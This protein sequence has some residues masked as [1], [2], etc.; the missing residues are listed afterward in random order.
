[1]NENSCDTCR[2]Q[3]KGEN[4]VPCIECNKRYQNKYTP[5]TNGDRIRQMSDEELAVELMCPYGS[6]GPV[7]G[8]NGKTCKECTLQWLR[9]VAE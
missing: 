7:C 6:E 3:D 5:M 2:Y 8:V 9:E 1:M 4:E